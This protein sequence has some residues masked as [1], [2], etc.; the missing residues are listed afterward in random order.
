MI[1]YLAEHR[2]TMPEW[3]VGWRPDS[4][5][6]IEDF[7]SSRLLYYPGSGFDGQPISSFNRAK[8]AS[9]FVY[10]DYGCSKHRLRAELANPASGFRG[11]RTLG[12]IDLQQNNLA[13]AGWTPHVTPTRAPRSTGYVA[14]FAFLQVLERE[15]EYGV[16]HGQ[17]RLAVLF[18]AADGIAAFDALFC[19]TGHPRSAPYCIVLQDHAFGGNYDSFGA[20]GLLERL[21]V[22]KDR[23]PDMLMVAANTQPWSGYSDAPNSTSHGGMHK[24]RRSMYF[25]SR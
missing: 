8:A 18:L 21:A 25:R 17:D 12:Q 15:A 20:G 13:P 2:T 16:E 1:G 5:F 7:F 14:P 23:R 19:Q 24:M 3:L 11:Y 6:N 4:P 22:Q 10:V 9:C